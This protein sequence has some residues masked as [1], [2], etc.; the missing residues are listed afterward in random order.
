MEIYNVY[1]E[2]IY[3]S[4]ITNTKSEIDLRNQTNGLYFVKIY[5]GK[6]ILTKKI[7]IE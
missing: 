5:K 7:V 1:G 2:I 6:T 4:P 3:Q